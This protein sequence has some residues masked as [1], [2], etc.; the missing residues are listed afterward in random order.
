VFQRDSW[1]CAP[2]THLHNCARRIQDLSCV[3]LESIGNRDA[4]RCR[5]RCVP[6]FGVVSTESGDQS[7]AF[8]SPK[9]PG[10]S[11]YRRLPDIQSR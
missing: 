1:P 2:L 5:V 6:E 7:R 11:R 3:D 9:R 8:T 10:S 4:Q